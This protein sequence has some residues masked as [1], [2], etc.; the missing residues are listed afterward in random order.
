MYK[1]LKQKEICSYCGVKLRISIV[2]RPKNTCMKCWKHQR[3]YCPGLQQQ[4]DAEENLYNDL[5][6]D[7]YYKKHP[8]LTKIYF[9]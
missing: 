7:E 2:N 1:E 3:K 6:L 4:L 5:Q 8:E 9:L